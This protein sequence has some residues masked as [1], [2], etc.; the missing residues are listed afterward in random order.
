M[1]PG[2]ASSVRRCNLNYMSTDEKASTPAGETLRGWFT[3]RLPGDW[4]TAPP[5]V[6]I[7]R[8]EI[9]VLGALTDPQV[10]AGA[11]PAQSA[12]AAGGPGRT[13]RRPGAPRP[14]TAGAEGS[15][16]RPGSTG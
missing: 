4:Y 9:T 13:A 5:E 3:G 10:A 8:E 15:G 14:P 16:R 12:A 1:P 2:L 6:T 7:D 11:P